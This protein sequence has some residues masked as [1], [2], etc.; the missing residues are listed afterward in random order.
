MANTL[1]FV[2]YQAVV[3]R[4]ILRQAELLGYLRPS[5]GTFISRIAFRVLGIFNAAVLSVRRAFE[6][7]SA[8][9][10]LELFPGQSSLESQR[11]HDYLCLLFH[12]HFGRASIGTF[13]SFIQHLLQLSA[14]AMKMN[15]LHRN[16]PSFNDG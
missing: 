15:Y 6:L 3:Y 1:P 2:H 13:L 9:L 5:T 11:K 14:H 10:H 12:V 8:R 16:S 7:P 4:R